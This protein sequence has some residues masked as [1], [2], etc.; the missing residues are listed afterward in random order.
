[1]TLMPDHVHLL[2]TLGQHT[3]P[4]RAI[5]RMKAKTRAPLTARQA[6]WQANYYDHQLRSSES[7]EPVIRYIW[8]NPYAAGL[9][10]LERPWPHFWCGEEDWNWFRSVTDAGAPFPDWLR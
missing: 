3:A 9:S 7:I 6:A 5:A 4:S 2:V 10:P 1:M 8:L